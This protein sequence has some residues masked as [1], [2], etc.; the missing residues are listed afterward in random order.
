MT[1]LGALVMLALLILLV[2][3]L[4]LAIIAYRAKATIA[5]LLLMLASICF[6]LP[7]VVV[8]V[9]GLFFYIRGGKPSGSMA[10]WMHSWWHPVYLSFDFLFLALIIGAFVLF[11]RERRRI[12]TP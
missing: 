11:I 6:C 4:I 8:V 2:A 12:V 1:L 10:T 3:F 9:I 5:F 7:R